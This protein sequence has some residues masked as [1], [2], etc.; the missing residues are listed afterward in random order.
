MDIKLITGDIN[1]IKADA[2]I[3]SIFEDAEGSELEKDLDKALAGAVAEL[4]KKKEIRGKASELTVIHS[5]G[6]I[7]AAKAAILGLGKKKELDAARLRSAVADACRGLQRKNNVELAL[8][9]P[10]TSLSV[11]DIGRVTAEAAYLGSYSYRRHLTKEAEYGDIKS[12]VV[13]F[14]TKLDKDEFDRGARKGEITAQAIRLA[15]DMAN[16]PSNHMAPEDM[17]DIAEKVGRESGVKVEVLDRKDMEKL[18]MGGLLGVSQASFEKHPPK[19]IIMRYKG[20]DGESWDLALV[21]KGLTF[22]TGGISIKP[23][24][25]MED[26][27]FDMSGGAAAIAAMSAIG[28]LK[29]KINVIAAVPATENMP[30]GGAY[31]PGDVLKMFTG[32]TVEVISTD[33]EGRLILADAL[34]YLVKEAKPRAIIDMAT[35]TGACVIALGGITTAAITNNQP[36]CDKVIRAGSVAGERIWQLPAYDEYKEQYKSDYADIKNVGGR[37]AGTITAGLF[38]GEFVGE[39]PWVHLDIAGTAYGEREKGHLT[40]G[41]S[42]VPV[43]TLVSLAEML[44][45]E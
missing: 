4:R 33:A 12:L 10:E 31:K 13:L 17:A 21:G 2:V 15:R 40:K 30:G 22:D 38:L 28:K 18:G 20:G 8:A 45:G 27:K 5:L 9:L 24:D 3:V 29:L 7:N 32:K 41:G 37:P 44:A 39:T 11:S 43:A 16:E 34:G 6:K 35:L 36:L 42:G 25:K 23:A 14:E 19:L 1:K 26:M